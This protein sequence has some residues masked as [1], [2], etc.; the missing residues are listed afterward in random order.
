MAVPHL[1][2]GRVVSLD[3]RRVALHVWYAG[4]RPRWIRARCEWDPRVPGFAD[5]A[6]CTACMRVHGRHGL[7]TELHG[8]DAAGPNGTRMNQR[9]EEGVTI[10]IR[11]RNGLTVV[12]RGRDGP[13][14][15]YTPIV[16][17]MEGPD[18]RVGQ[19]GRRV[20][21]MRSVADSESER[22]AT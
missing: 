7:V 10:V 13:R 3:P 16:C 19:H 12:I 15:R 22:S 18:G 9:S 1:G 21:V 11:G 8:Q 2:A 14:E 5:A 6:A 4:R 20:L 17:A